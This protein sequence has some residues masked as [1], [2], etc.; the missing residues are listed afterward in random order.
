MA[1]TWERAAI[2]TAHS[3]K[4]EPKSEPQLTKGSLEISASI[5]PDLLSDKTHT[6][7]HTLRNLH[8]N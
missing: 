8:S 5:C 6:E 7:R 4:N 1:Y 3:L 2:R